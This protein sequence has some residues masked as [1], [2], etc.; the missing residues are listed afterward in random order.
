MQVKTTTRCHYIAIRMVKIKGIV[1]AWL[2]Q[3]CEA[4]RTPINYKQEHKLVQPLW[5]TVMQYLQRHI[6]Y[7]SA[8]PLLGKYPTEMT[9]YI[10]QRICTR[11]FMRFF[12]ILAKWNKCPL[13]V[14]Q[15]NKLWHNHTMKHYPAMKPPSCY[16]EQ[17]RQF[18]THNASKRNQ[19]QKENAVNDA[20]LHEAQK[21]AELIFTIRR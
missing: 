21:L 3:E 15:T 6:A 18:H 9:A 8:S 17:Y 20:I 14:E 2:W 4:P 16:T 11:K 13:I 10:L 1:I 7:N 12:F 5:K 19:T